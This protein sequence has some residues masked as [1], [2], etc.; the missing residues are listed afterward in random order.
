MER[1]ATTY[2]ELSEQSEVKRGIRK[3]C[4]KISTFSHVPLNR[5]QVE[6]MKPFASDAMADFMVDVLKK[7]NIPDE[8]LHHFSAVTYWYSLALITLNSSPKSIAYLEQLTESLTAV[9]H[10]TVSLLR[11][12]FESAQE[13]PAIAPLQEAIER[14]YQALKPEIEA[15][16]WATET[17]LVVPEN[18]YKWNVD[19]I[20]T[21]DGETWRDVN[22]LSEKEKLECVSM[23][24]KVFGEALGDGKSWEIIVRN[25]DKMLARWPGSAPQ[26]IKTAKG[27]YADLGTNP[28]LLNLK[29]LIKETESILGV[30]FQRKL[31]HSEFSKGIRNKN[32]VQEWLDEEG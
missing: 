25:P 4:K 3:F 12:L 26:K 24:V 9:K 1:L 17:G 11:K 21:T 13:K 15:Y 20:L 8:R 6:R 5:K 22:K 28:S 31:A 19:L 2:L 27:G 7:Y 23:T 14:Y 30:K 29:D 16:S 10:E 18:N 32:A